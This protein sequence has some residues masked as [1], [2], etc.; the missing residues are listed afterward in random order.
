M[1]PLVENSPTRLNV[2]TSYIMERAP[3]RLHVVIVVIFE[4]IYSIIQ[5]CSSGSV[6]GKFDAMLI[7]YYEYAQAN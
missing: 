1:L 2:L 3:N 5:F 6:L 4:Y 7:F